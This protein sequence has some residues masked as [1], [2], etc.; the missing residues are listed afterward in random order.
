MLT[1]IKWADNVLNII[2]RN[3]AGDY[4]KIESAQYKQKAE[5]LMT[6]TC[7]SELRYW[8]LDFSCDL[9]TLKIEN[10]TQLKIVSSRKT[11]NS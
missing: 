5:T 7:Y 11:D 10:K 3:R 6:E 4:L 9:E 1:V 2:C 8:N